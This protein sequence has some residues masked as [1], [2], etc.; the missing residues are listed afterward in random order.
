MLVP[1][2]TK[3][4][5]WEILY[6]SGK[7][8]PGVARVEIQLPSGLE[9]HKP[10]GGKKARIKDI[11]VPPAEIDI[12]LEL[13]PAEMPAL[14]RVIDLLRPRAASG[15][16]K[17]LEIA[18]PNAAMWGINIIKI[19]DIG[20]P[21]PGPGGSFTLKLSA[22]EHVDAPKAVKKPAEKP[23]SDDPSEWNVGPLIDELRPSRQGAPQ[24]NFS[25]GVEP[26]FSEGEIP[27][28]GF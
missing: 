25:S 17:P 3:D 20:S 21:Q 6:L 11:G 12:E 9:V 18:H 16:C 10:R 26:T 27:G 19:R 13:L 28:S 8:M 22:Y 7:R 23:Q 1:D 2:W 14:Q 24:A 15:A 5:S 4:E